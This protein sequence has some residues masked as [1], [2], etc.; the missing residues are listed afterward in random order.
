MI[1]QG[2]MKLLFPKR[3]FFQLEFWFV[4]HRILMVSVVLFSIAGLL[5]ILAFKDWKWV[6][7][8]TKKEFAHS[9]TGIITIALSVLQVRD[10]S[11][12]DTKLGD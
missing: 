1:Y 6:S 4:A 2:Y 9:I 7:T 3:K 5:L 10:K 11:C 12:H 8:I